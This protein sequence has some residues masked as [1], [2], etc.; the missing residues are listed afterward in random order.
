MA[1]Y[2]NGPK[3]SDRHLERPK[4]QFRHIAIM[5]HSA[6][7]SLCSATLAVKYSASGGS[8]S[9]CQPVSARNLT[10]SGRGMDVRV[11][12]AVKPPSTQILKKKDKTTK[13]VAS[14]HSRWP[15]SVPSVPLHPPHRHL[16]AQHS[17]PCAAP[18]HV[19][20]PHSRGQSPS[21]RGPVCRPPSPPFARRPLLLPATHARASSLESPGWSAASPTI[22]FAV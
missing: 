4:C 14:P 15:I 11:T 2:R 18:L 19:A 16:F 20:P 22:R 12:P 3:H 6:P 9:L 7:I 1:S 13:S 21:E 5:R 8:T 17:A 10:D